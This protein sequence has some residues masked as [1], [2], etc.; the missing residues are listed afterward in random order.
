MFFVFEL[1]NGRKLLDPAQEVIKNQFVKL[2]FANNHFHICSLNEF[3]A[4]LAY[5]FHLA[6]VDIEAL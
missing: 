4:A 3:K 2:G 1:K 6:G 5:A